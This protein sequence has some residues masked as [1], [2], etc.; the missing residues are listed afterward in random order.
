[1]TP[2][3]WPCGAAVD[4]RAACLA[5]MHSGAALTVPAPTPADCAQASSRHH[6]EASALVICRAVLDAVDHRRPGPPTHR[7]SRPCSC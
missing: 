5:R 6:K 1:M 4:V 7:R 3:W 2:R